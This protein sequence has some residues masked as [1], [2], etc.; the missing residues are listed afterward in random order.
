M[1]RTILVTGA[2]GHLGRRVAAR[3][4]AEGWTVVGTFHTAQP[5]LPGVG[6][7]RLDLRDRA[8]VEG[9]LTELAPDVV[10]HAAAGRDRDDWAVIAEG[11][12]AVAAAAA[13]VGAR[14]VHVSS[15]AVL[16]G[17]NPPY[18][19]TALPDPVTRYG[20]AKAAA[21]T[22]VRTV[23]PGAVIARVSLILGDGDSKHER[24]VHALHAGEDGALFTDR[25][26]MPSHAAD[27]AAALLELAGTGHAGVVNLAGSD[28]VSYHELGCL[29]AERD[30]LD[31]ARLPAAR[32]QDRGVVL[33]AD[34]RLDTTLATEL[35][36]TRVRGVRELFGQR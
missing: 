20:A 5:E 19:E 2:S 28:R 7:R 11:A 13:A 23:A 27:L 1:T 24:L 30:G 21:E 26:R 10:V 15:D 14:L 3:S 35:L 16:S 36:T 8:M 31:P 32:A 29:I 6:W 4:V 9:L 22:A 12:G 34:T 18:D 25:Y 17:A 33:S